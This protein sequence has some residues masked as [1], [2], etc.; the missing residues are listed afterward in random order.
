MS[1]D[2]SS[3][4]TTTGTN[5]EVP[6]IQNAEHINVEKQRISEEQFNEL[7][8]IKEKGEDDYERI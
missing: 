6:A 4:I 8:K 5:S 1:N 3:E 2:S 7:K